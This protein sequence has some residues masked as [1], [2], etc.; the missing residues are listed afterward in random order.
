MKMAVI[1]ET[2]QFCEVLEE[3]PQRVV[4]RVF[5]DNHVLTLDPCEVWVLT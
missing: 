4:V 2:Q 5:D 3:T 1:F